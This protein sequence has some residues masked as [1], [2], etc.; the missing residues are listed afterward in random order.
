MFRKEPLII[1]DGFF[2]FFYLARMQ[3]Y[4]RRKGAEYKISS[5]LVL[6]Y[7]HRTLLVF[8][9]VFFRCNG[10]HIYLY[11]FWVLQRKNLKKIPCYS[12][13]KVIQQKCPSYG[14]NSINQ[15]RLH[16]RKERTN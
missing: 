6:L 4:F 3:L 1:V 16:K 12:K 13:S 7:S 9:F 14:Q 11:I 5:I 10:W 2:F 15:Y 8:V